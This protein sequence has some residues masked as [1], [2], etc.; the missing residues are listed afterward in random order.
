[1]TLK[2]W[3]PIF[4]SIVALLFSLYTY[5][6][7]SLNREF[8]QR[9]LKIMYQLIDKLQDTIFQIAAIGIQ[10]PP[11]I[12]SGTMCRFFQIGTDYRNYAEFID[13]DALLV[14][15]DP[16]LQYDFISFSEHP[17]MVPEVATI[18]RQFM[19]YTFEPMD[20]SQLRSYTILGGSG[21]P[22]YDGSYYRIDDNP[23]YK[24]LKT[25]FDQCQVLDKAIHKWLK[26]IGIKD[27][28]KKV[29]IE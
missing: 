4:I 9:Q 8:K 2:D 20:T 23:V 11:V 24:N 22:R 21:I 13:T 25:F 6:K 19:S 10:K 18:L 15:K 12:S 7:V 3:L 14:T 17:M 26:S 1:M 29:I 27:F 28:N 16:D 5:S